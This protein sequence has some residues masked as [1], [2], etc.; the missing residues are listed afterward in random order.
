MVLYSSHF[1]KPWVTAFSFHWFSISEPNGSGK[2]SMT[3]MVSTLR[4]TTRRIAVT[5]SLRVAEPSIGVVDDATSLC[6][7]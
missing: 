2:L 5:R 1:K 7:E 4:C 6:L 3:R